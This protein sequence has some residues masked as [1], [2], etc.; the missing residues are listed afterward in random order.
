MKAT[1]AFRVFSGWSLGMNSKMAIKTV[2]RVV[3]APTISSQLRDEINVI[4]LIMSMIR[5][6]VRV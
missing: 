3:I 1:T 6:F 2:R 5:C 4:R